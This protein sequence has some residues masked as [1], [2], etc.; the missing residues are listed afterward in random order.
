MT[1]GRLIVPILFA[2]L[3][4]GCGSA[5]ILQK[6]SSGPGPDES[7]I[8]LGVKPDRFRL[9]LREGTYSADGVTVDRVWGRGAVI[10]GAAQ[11]GYLIAKAKAGQVLVVSDVFPEY[12]WSYGGCSE[13]ISLVFE[14]PKGQ[15]AYV[16]DVEYQE[17]D[18]ELLVQYVN[19]VAEARQHVRAN[20]PRLRQ[21]VQ[22][23]SAQILPVRSKCNNGGAIFLPTRVIR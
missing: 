8:V 13:N 1:F 11:D 4:G 12:G 19:R 17:R 20:Y 3:L 2:A 22:Q 18:R 23:L 5:A 10:N 16:T 15:I 6:D 9:H 14:V 7:V 21:E